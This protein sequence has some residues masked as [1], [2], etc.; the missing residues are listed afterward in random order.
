MYPT[1]SGDHGLAFVSRFDV[2]VRVGDVVQ[3][4]HPNRA[5]KAWAQRN[6]NRGLLIKRIAG[7]EGY[8]GYM[9]SCWRGPPAS[10]VVVARGYCWILGDN[11][12][13]STDSRRFGPVPLVFLLGKVKWQLGPETFDFIAHDPNYEAT[14]G[15]SIRPDADLET[16]E[17]TVRLILKTTP[18]TITGSKS[19]LRYKISDT[20]REEPVDRSSS[21]RTKSSGAANRV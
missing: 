20:K 17:P 15:Q 14:T 8:C 2:S 9:R 16:P 4:I 18:P 21:K 19:H 1:F 3:L 7:F 13:A 5:D 12:S 6:R 10:K 11:R